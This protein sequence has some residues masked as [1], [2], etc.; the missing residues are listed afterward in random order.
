MRIAVDAGAGLV[1]A[2]AAEFEQG[3]DIR[4]PISA[5]KVFVSEA[6]VTH[7]LQAMQI[8]GGY[9]YMREFDLERLFRDM[10][11]MTVGGGTNEIHRDMI[12]KQMLA[13][14]DR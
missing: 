3:G 6:A 2:A 10:K 8:L 9:G 4:L 5:A 13:E 1:A 12:A 11:L 14:A 7:G